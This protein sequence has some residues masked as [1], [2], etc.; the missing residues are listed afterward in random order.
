M[1]PTHTIADYGEHTIE[2]PLGTALVSSHYPGAWRPD[3]YFLG[4]LVISAGG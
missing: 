1:L 3:I 4:I 2:N